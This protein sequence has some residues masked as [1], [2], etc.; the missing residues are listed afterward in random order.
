M[1]PHSDRG[2]Q[3]TS[4]E[5]Q[6]FVADHGIVSS[7]SDVG[8]CYDNAVAESFFGLLKR[9]RVNRRRYRARAE[10]RSAIKDG[11]TVGIRVK[12]KSEAYDIWQWSAKKDGTIFP[13]LTP[14]NDFTVLVGLA[15]ARADMLFYVVPTPV[16]DKWLRDDHEEWLRT[17]GKKGQKHSPDNR[18]RHLSLS[19]FGKALEPYRE[20]WTGPW[21]A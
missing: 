16:L 8:S 18:K 3:Y 11:A 12:T 6:R 13:G 19:K 14:R 15:E 10:A 9:E 20:A 2:T 5:Y 1:I 7:M 21:E 4:A 17:P